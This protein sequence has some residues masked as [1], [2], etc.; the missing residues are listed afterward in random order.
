MLKLQAN[1]NG[2]NYYMQMLEYIN[3]LKHLKI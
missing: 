3:K 2:K 1:Y